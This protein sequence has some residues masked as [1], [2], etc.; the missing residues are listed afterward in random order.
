M[1]LAELSQQGHVPI[2][3]DSDVQTRLAGRFNMTPQRFLDTAT[4]DNGLDWYFDGAVVRVSRASARRTLA[5][6]LVYAEPE[7]LFSVLRETR[8]ADPRFPPQLRA[9]GLES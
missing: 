6:R 9:K 2:V 1:H 5:I 7:E 4:S 8:I 3:V